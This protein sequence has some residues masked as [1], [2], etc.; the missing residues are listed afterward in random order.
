MTTADPLVWRTSSRSSD[1]ENCV[2]VAPAV[3]GVII[4]HS[5][6]PAA[7]TITFTYPAWDAFMGEALENLGSNNGI[8]TITKVGSDT[9][10]K[11][12]H[13]TAELRF[14]ADEWSAFC[15]GANDGEFDF[16]SQA[17]SAI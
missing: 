10:V 8:A 1:G 15:A 4:R 7:G 3:D 16:S 6:D 11:S 14:D 13:V 17:A 12:L 9:L 2:E 5:K